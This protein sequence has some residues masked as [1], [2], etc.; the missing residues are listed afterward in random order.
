MRIAGNMVPMVERLRNGRCPTWLLGLFSLAI[1]AGS[2]ISALGEDTDSASAKAAAAGG[3]GQ[4]FIEFRARYAWDYG[5]TF[6]V[7]GRV[8]EPLTKA[9]FAGLSP[10]GDDATAW[11]VGHYV[12]V[13]AETGWTDGDLEDNYI[14]ARYRVYMNKAQYDRV[15][16]FVRQLQQQARVECGIVYC[17]AF[18]CD[19]AQY[20]G[21]RVPKSTLIY[22]KVFINNFRQINSH[23]GMAD[24]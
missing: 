24:C 17:N 13:P 3:G 23:P 2:G 6:I 14:S 19:I 11:V 5:H 8:G 1:L 7:H 12:P 21:L 20:M 22:P 10:A 4:Y 15:M 9:N 18:V 16:V